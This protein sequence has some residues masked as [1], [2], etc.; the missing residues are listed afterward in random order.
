[1]AHERSGQ[2]CKVRISLALIERDRGSIKRS[3][4]TS[5]QTPANVRAPFSSV[6]IPAQRRHARAADEAFE[7][8]VEKALVLLVS[9]QQHS[10]M[11]IQSQRFQ[12]VI[13]YGVEPSQVINRA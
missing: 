1:M 4:R 5:P 12:Q 9:L 10:R 13:V 11:S 2:I 3:R 6:H 7:F 8:L